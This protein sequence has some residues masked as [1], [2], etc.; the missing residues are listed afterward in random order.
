MYVSMVV[1]VCICVCECVCMKVHRI[2]I[3]KKTDTGMNTICSH[4]KQ[5]SLKMP[6]CVSACVHDVTLC[7][8]S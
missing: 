1:Y 3:Q 8:V 7:T 6:G 2:C 4:I 5:V